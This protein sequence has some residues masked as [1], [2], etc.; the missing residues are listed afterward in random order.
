MVGMGLLCVFLSTECVELVE[1]ALQG[2]EQPAP[3]CLEGASLCFSSY[4]INFI[5]V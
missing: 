2:W 4:L 3:R 5:G 1:C